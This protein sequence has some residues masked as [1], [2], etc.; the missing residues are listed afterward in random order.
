MTCN[1]HYARHCTNTKLQK[2]LSEDPESR[3]TQ[4]SF[5]STALLLLL[6]VKFTE[7]VLQLK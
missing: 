6:S 7:N 1:S 2:K 3:Q 4:I 5:D